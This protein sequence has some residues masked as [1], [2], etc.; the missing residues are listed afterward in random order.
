LAGLLR[1]VGGLL[2]LQGTLA[3]LEGPLR[4]AEPVHGGGDVPDRD[5]RVLAGLLRR[6]LVPEKS[7]LSGPEDPLP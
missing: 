7:V 1:P 5:A 3:G 6:L 4:G 2:A